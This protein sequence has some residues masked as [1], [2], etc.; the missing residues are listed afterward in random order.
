[1]I[2]RSF[3]ESEFTLR[4]INR[5]FTESEFTLRMINRTFTETANGESGNC[6]RYVEDRPRPSLLSFDCDGQSPCP[7]T[8]AAERQTG[9]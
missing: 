9:G 1:M 6:D 4:M 7:V 2:N 8:K 3:T 5:S